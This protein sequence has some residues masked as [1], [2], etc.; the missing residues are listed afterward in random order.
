[1]KTILKFTFAFL[2]MFGGVAFALL[3]EHWLVNYYF[4]ERF[5]VGAVLFILGAY[6]WYVLDVRMEKHGRC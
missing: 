4:I 5:T 1:M 6:Y 2:L 3:G